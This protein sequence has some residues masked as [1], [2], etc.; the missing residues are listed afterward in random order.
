MVYGYEEDELLLGIIYSFLATLPFAVI[1]VWIFAGYISTFVT[2]LFVAGFLII[3][4]VCYFLGLILF[5]PEEESS[6]QPS[7]PN[8]APKKKK[9]KKKKKK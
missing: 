7:S 2:I 4:A 8:K 3:L 5:L 6:V 1:W 9:K